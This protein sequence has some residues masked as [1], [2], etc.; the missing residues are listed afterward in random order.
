M[1]RL[2]L[3]LGVATLLVTSGAD[4]RQAH[5]NWR[6]QNMKPS[7]V[8]FHFGTGGSAD[9]GV[10]AGRSTYVDFPMRITKAE[11][12]ADKDDDK[13]DGLFRIDRSGR[14]LRVAVHSSA[15]SAAEVQVQ[16]VFGDKKKASLVFHVVPKDKA[17][18]LVEVRRGS[19]KDAIR[20]YI[21]TEAG[22][23]ADRIIAKVEAVAAKKI[24]NAEAETSR[25]KDEARKQTIRLQEQTKEAVAKAQADA[26]R[27]R[28]ATESE[29]LVQEGKRI[30]TRHERL[31]PLYRTVTENKGYFVSLTLDVAGWDKN[32]TWLLVPFT[33][34][35]RE[36]EPYRFS[37]AKVTN[38]AGLV[39]ESMISWIE[40]PA[41]GAEIAN[42]GVN[43][44]M[45][46]VI[47]IRPP[48][49]ASIEQL[50]I[51]LSE[52]DSDRSLLASIHGWRSQ[53]VVMQARSAR[54][55]LLEKLRQVEAREA[56]GKQLILSAR[57]VGGA[58][59]LE[60]GL[61]ADRTE[62][63]PFGGLAVRLVKGFTESL[64]FEAEITGGKTGSAEFD[65]MMFMGEQGELSRSASLGRVAAG[66]LLR[67][68]HKTIP[69]FRFGVGL[70]GINYDSEF[71]TNGNA[72]PGP[73]TSVEFTGLV[74]FGTGLD[75]RLGDNF[76]AGA[77]ITAVLGFEQLKTL[78]AGV[79]VGYGW[80]PGSQAR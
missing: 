69:Y 64:A 40:K 33:I 75:I 71:M 53:T 37:E 10:A 9:V 11:S 46:G 6:W 32:L 55:Q 17:E 27:Q 1:R 77:A 43:E 34:D 48:P 41:E 5:A 65:D 13:D 73:D 45:S 12:V 25:V 47:A 79:H 49:G 42:I 19:A 7:M 76:V 36:S 35:N 38:S 66:G 16:V 78:E 63:A 14:R 54:D 21:E 50:K 28:I 58:Q 26:E 15:T 62:A 4:L 31:V 8:L 59:W 60:D 24:A 52:P 20:V 51:E 68:G 29:Q 2:L 18:L 74:S 80:N 3:L 44:R 30:P 67:F 72:V 22:R 23:I 61:G 39:Y 56:R 57:L 70:E